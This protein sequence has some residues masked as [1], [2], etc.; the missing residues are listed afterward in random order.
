MNADQQG[1][2][3]WSGE[4]DAH[5]PFWAT[6]L[7]SFTHKTKQEE[8]EEE[9]SLSFTAM[10]MLSALRRGVCQVGTLARQ[11][12]TLSASASA[13]NSPNLTVDLAADIQQTH[14][15]LLRNPFT[16]YAQQL[17]AIKVRARVE[18]S[19]SLDVLAA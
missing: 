8:E 10:M 19:L 17:E 12:R 9:L 2:V 15:N 5:F 4:Q 18:G 3:S 16:A 6:P 7:L 14:T 1:V 11:A 13:W